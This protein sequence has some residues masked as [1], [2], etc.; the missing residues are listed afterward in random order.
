MLL[1]NNKYLKIV[2]DIKKEISSAQHKAMLS[3][4]KELILLYWQIGNIINTHKEWGNKFIENL[5]RDIHLDFPNV[6][7]YSVRNLKYMAKFAGSYKEIQ[8]V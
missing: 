8:I 6:K 5:S 3:A 4:N 1:D 7:G 2:N